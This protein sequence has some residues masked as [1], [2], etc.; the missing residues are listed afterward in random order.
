MTSSVWNYGFLLHNLFLD[1]EVHSLQRLAS[2][3]IM[4]AYPC[5]YFASF[6]EFLCSLLAVLKL[7]L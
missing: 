1:L 2:T 3:I 4:Y 6:L 7:T 5:V